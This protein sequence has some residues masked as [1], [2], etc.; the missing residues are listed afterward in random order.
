MAKP[1]DSGDTSM[2]THSQ[3]LQLLRDFLATPD[4]AALRRKFM[5]FLAHDALREYREKKRALDS[6]IGDRLLCPRC[7]GDTFDEV[8]SDVPCRRCKIVPAGPGLGSIP[9]P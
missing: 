4:D 8:G 3:I 7:W 1:G 9:T 5:R 6:G 2:T